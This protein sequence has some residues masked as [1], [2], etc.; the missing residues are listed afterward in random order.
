MSHDINPLF[1]SLMHQYKNLC[2]AGQ[3][4]TEAASD[5]F[6]AAYDY[7]PEEFKKALQDAAVEMGLMPEKPDGY[8]DDGEPLYLA[9]DA[10]ARLGIDPDEMP[11]HLKRHIRTGNLNRAQ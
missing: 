8:S 5:L 2:E 7:A 9:N 4:H 10:L 1:F 11:E 6:S 3:Q